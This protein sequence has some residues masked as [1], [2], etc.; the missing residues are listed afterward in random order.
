MLIDVWGLSLL[1]CRPENAQQ[2]KKLIS[3]L[4]DIAQKWIEIFGSKKCFFLSYLLF[5]VS[6]QKTEKTPDCLQ[7]NWE[8]F[9]LSDFLS[10]PPISTADQNFKGL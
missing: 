8:K 5:L 9:I 2:I 7:L 4:P 6:I 1:L 3:L 10:E